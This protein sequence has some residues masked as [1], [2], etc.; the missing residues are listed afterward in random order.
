MI[1]WLSRLFVLALVLGACRP[2]SSSSRLAYGSE[3]DIEKLL[4]AHGV[5]AK[6]RSC[7]NVR[8]G[9][10]VIRSLACETDLSA[11]ELATLTSSLGT[12]PG[13]MGGY[14]GDTGSCEKRA[15]FANGTPGMSTEWAAS[16]KKQTSGISK[17]E[18]RR[19][20][21]GAA[22]IQIAYGWG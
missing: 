17:M 10:G 18:I 6:L 9:G 1:A 22:C 15:A 5:K 3:H 11:A 16:P 2:T 20:P 12:S 19:L 7:D 4:D 21:S 8:L 14:T 13:E